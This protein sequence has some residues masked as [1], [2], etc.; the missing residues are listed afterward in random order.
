MENKIFEEMFNVE[1]EHWWFVS[2]RKIITKF[3]EGLELK[4]DAR[5]LDAGCGNGDNLEMLAK[6]GE[7]FAVERDELAFARAQARLFGKVYKGE[8]PD[9]FPEE[10]SKDNDLIVLLDVLEHI[11]D[12]HKSLSV[13]KDC[14]KD[15]A[16]IV[17]TVPAYQF[18]WT[19]HDEIHHH[20][21]R[22]TI[23]S[24][25]KVVE[26]NG[27]KIQYISYFNTFLFPLALIDRLIKKL[28]FSSRE[29]KLVIPNK[30]INVVF[31][32][33]FGFESNFIGKYSFPFGL[34]IILVAENI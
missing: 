8:L 32:K 3:I 15:K 4:D 7:L 21:R 10:V 13:L 25:K 19:Q 28:L 31:E 27:W 34:S 22:Y 20:K 16:K 17:I 11:D 23:K 9:G 30:H 26:A 5:V 14:A 2:R 24:L 18:L 12:D 6:H 33:I 1:A 29:E